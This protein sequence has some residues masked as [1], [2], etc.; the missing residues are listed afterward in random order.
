MGSTAEWKGQKKES[1]NY[2]TKQQK[3]SNFNN[4][5]KKN[6]KNEQHLRD[7]WDYIK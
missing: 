7:L 4:K 2:K 1:V 3:L 5:E 6:Q